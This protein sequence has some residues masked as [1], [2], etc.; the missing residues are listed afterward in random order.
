MSTAVCKELLSAEQQAALLRWDQISL[1]EAQCNTILE[2]MELKA[3]PI[4][5]CI[6][7][8]RAMEK[9]L[10]QWYGYGL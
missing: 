8:A 4:L 1:S 7:Q 3:L 9:A 6:A 2:A 5:L 10:W